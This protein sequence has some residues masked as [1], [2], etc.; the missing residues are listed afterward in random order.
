MARIF[1]VLALL[2]VLLL[3]SNFVV[4]LAGGDF[5]GAARA[6]R[7]AQRKYL[8]LER[9]GRGARAVAAEEL[10][11]ARAAAA[12]ADQQFARPRSW[13]TLHMLLGSAA[14]L[15]TVLVNSITITYFIGTSRWCK[16]VC[17]TYRL[18]ADLAHRSTQLKRGTFPWALAGI[19]SIIAVVGFGAAAD[20]SGANWQNSA[21]FVTPHYVVAML[22]MVIVCAAFWM[23]IQRIA[24]NH[25][26]IDEILAEVQQIR[27][28][29][30]L[31]TESPAISV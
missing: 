21:S 8:E 12:A 28:E 2:A 23:Q 25:L 17:A 30:N 19:L 24:E 1:S 10:E 3:A 16:E 6:K 14:A 7:E 13:M 15:I 27:S 11:Q 22:A 20:A 18:S 26:V 9:T 29:R 31:P 4:G 5:N